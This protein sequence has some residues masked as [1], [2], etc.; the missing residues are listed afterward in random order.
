MVRRKY[1]N[2]DAS[3]EKAGCEFTP[4]ESPGEDNAKTVDNM[5][6]GPVGEQRSSAN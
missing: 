3:I 6:T 1:L 4:K 5:P 2:A